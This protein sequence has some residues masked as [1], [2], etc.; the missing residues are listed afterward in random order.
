VRAPVD[1]RGGFVELG[2]GVERDHPSQLLGEE[3][4]EVTVHRLGSDGVG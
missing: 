2:D 1:L 3:P 4:E